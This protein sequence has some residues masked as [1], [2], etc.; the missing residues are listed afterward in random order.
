MPGRP[1]IEEI[2]ARAELATKGPWSVL[3]GYER[4]GYIEGPESGPYG[5]PTFKYAADVDFAAHSRTDVP[6]LCEWALG[7]EAKLKFA[8]KALQNIHDTPVGGLAYRKQAEHMRA[9][10]DGAIG[11]LGKEQDDG[12]D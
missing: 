12:T 10:A 8:R 1:P 3:C 6:A 5:E 9:L 11:F 7:L 2:L 4:G